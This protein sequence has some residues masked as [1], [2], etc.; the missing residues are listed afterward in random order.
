MVAEADAVVD[1]WA[2]V[3][4]P[5]DTYVADTTVVT[6]I[7]LV[8]QAPLTMPPLA[9][10]F[11]FLR[12]WELDDAARPACTEPTFDVDEPPDIIVWHRTRSGQDSAC[13]TS[14]N[15]AD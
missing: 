5:Q 1:P 11:D 6:T 8:L 15:Q 10:H 7:W 3:V 13:I 2:V 9:T 12:S 14:K 4:H